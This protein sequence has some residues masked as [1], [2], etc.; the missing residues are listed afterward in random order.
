MPHTPDGEDPEKKILEKLRDEFGASYATTELEIRTKADIV[1]AFE[2]CDG[3]DKTRE[4]MEGQDEGT[5][6]KAADKHGMSEADYI[7]ATIAAAAE[8]SQAKAHV[9]YYALIYI[10]AGKDHSH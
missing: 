2:I 1:R 7:D 8:A 4:S 3:I 9:M 6:K 5:F 10:A